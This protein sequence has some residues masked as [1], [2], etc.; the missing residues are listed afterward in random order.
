MR[1]PFDGIIASGEVTSGEALERETLTSR[2]GLASRRAFLGWAA[3]ILGG[4]AAYLTPRPAQAKRR[5][6]T[7]S[8]RVKRRKDRIITHALSEEGSVTTYALGE[9]GGQ[10]HPSTKMRGEEGGSWPD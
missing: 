5:K 6:T 1:H 3:A 9:E 4:A 8:T 2:P 7:Q 10:G